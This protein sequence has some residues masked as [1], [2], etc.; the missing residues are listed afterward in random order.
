M[1]YTF[2]LQQQQSP[3]GVKVYYDCVN[4]EY[5]TL[6]FN[7]KVYKISLYRCHLSLEM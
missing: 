7:G 6:I 1:V 3:P 4:F 2:K 5:P